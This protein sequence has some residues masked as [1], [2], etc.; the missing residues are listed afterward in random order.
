MS[1]IYIFL[2]LSRNDLRIQDD[3]LVGPPDHVSDICNSFGFVS[4]CSPFLSPVSDRV[5]N[6]PPLPAFLR[7]K[8]CF[9]QN[10]EDEIPAPHQQLVRRVYT[11]WM[12]KFFILPYKPPPVLFKIIRRVHLW[13]FYQALQHLL[14]SPLLT[15]CSVFRHA[16]HECHL[17]HCLV[18]WRWKCHQFWLF[19]TLAHPLQPLQLHMLVQAAL[20]SL[21]VSH[22]P[23]LEPFLKDA[24]RTSLHHLFKNRDSAQ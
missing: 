8:P 13:C 20:Q 23:T 4:M 14:S 18:G 12:C 24:S 2:L 1:V 16:V 15:F 5:N 11:L 22:L 7:I 9:Y 3:R 19:S 17:L 6:F 10:I 21:Q